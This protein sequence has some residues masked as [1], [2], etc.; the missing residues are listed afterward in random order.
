M[1]EHTLHTRRKFLLTGVLGGALAWTLPTFFAKRFFALDASAA[2]AAIQTLS[3]KDSPILV[4]LQMAGGNDGLNTV[5][6]FADDSYY[7][8]RPNIGI[9]AG[10]LLKLTDEIGLNGKLAGLRGLYDS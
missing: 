4:V 8:A 1:N 3:G 2:D 7:A 9:P 10:K 6:P 5:I